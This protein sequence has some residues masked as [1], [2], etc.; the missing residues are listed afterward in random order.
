[1]NLRRMRKSH[2][3]LAGAL[4]LG[5]IMLAGGAG[6]QVQGQ[7]SNC[8]TMHASQDNL[9][10]GS[11]PFNVL[12][13]NDCIG[14]HSGTN[15][16]GTPPGTVSGT[17]APGVLDS[18]DPFTA[19]TFLAGGNFYSVEQGNDAHGHNVKGMVNNPDDATLLDVPPGYDGTNVNLGLAAPGLTCA[20]ATGCHGSDFANEDPEAQSFGAI[21]GGHHGQ[22]GIVDGST[23]G[24]SYRF[25]LGMPGGEA[26]DYEYA[27]SASNHNAYPGWARGDDSE[28][29][30]PATPGAIISMSQLCAK[31]HANFHNT[32]TG[33]TAAGID[34]GTWGNPWIRHPTDFDFSGLGGEYA[35]N[36]ATYNPLVPVG[37]DIT[38]VGAA[39]FQALVVQE[40]N[41]GVTGGNIVICLSC[42]RAH[43]SQYD[44]ILRWNYEDMV[45]GAP[46]GGMDENGC[47]YCHATKDGD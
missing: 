11:G 38:A 29:F 43:G 30:Y 39:N 9:P 8:H 14:C 1:M 20:G 27:P 33:G 44:D 31:C 40:T 28:D 26:P 47:F 22:T 42:H 7:C 4:G 24:Q 41:S 10:M 18:T 6:A 5:A 25:L 19:G 23:L 45:A 12:L 37:R 36:M 3:L 2:T 17:N 34:G 16:T 35:V 21:A 32:D 13:L 15:G 46:T